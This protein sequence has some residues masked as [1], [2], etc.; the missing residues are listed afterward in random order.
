MSL[1][2]TREGVSGSTLKQLQTVATDA[3]GRCSCLPERGNKLCI[4]RTKNK[5]TKDYLV[6]LGLWTDPTEY[7]G[8]PL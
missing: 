6:H 3:H 2:D 1:D 5:G 4:F 8:E 7:L